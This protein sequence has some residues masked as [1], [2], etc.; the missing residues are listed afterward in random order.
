MRILKISVIILLLSSTGCRE[1]LGHDSLSCCDKVKHTLSVIVIYKL[2]PIPSWTTPYSNSEGCYGCTNGI[3]W[4]PNSLRFM[5]GDLKIGFFFLEH[6]TWEIIPKF[7]Q[8]YLYVTK[9][10][11]PVA[12]VVMAALFPLSFSV[13][14]IKYKFW[15]INM[16]SLFEVFSI[17]FNICLYTD[18]PGNYHGILYSPFFS[19]DDT[20]L[21]NFDTGKLK[22]LF[23]I[24]FFPRI[25]IDMS[26]FY[27]NNKTSKH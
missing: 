26:C 19:I 13:V 9:D 16:F 25:S 14:S 18:S 11:L 2:L 20:F 1:V 4:Y 23:I 21:D 6:R 22:S 17:L 24:F 15:R 10:I 7:I 3:G 8:M 27:K 5:N 12:Y